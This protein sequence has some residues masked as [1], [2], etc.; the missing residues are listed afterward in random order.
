MLTRQLWKYSKQHLFSIFLGTVA[1][2]CLGIVTGLPSLFVK[3]LI[4]EVLVGKKTEHLPFFFFVFLGLFTAKA[5]FMYL[6]WMMHRVG[7]TI[8]CM[9]RKDFFDALID[10]SLEELTTFSDSS[11]K[12]YFMTDIPLM[13]NGIILFFRQGIKSVVETIFLLGIAWYRNPLLAALACTTLPLLFFFFK[14][15]S[16]YLRAYSHKTQ[17]ALEALNHHFQEI[18][19]GLLE[20]KMYQ[21]DEQEKNKYTA[22]NNAYTTAAIKS[23]HCEAAI[24]AL[25][26][27]FIFGALC[28]VLSIGLYQVKQA[29]ITIGDLTSFFMALLLAYQP[30]RRSVAII[31]EIQN[32][33]AAAE[34]ILSIINELKKRAEPKS[35]TKTLTFNQSIVLQNVSYSYNN[36]APVLK[37]INL[38]IYPGDRIALIGPSG[39]GKSTLC[40]LLL[41]FL[42]PT[43]GTIL[44]DEKALSSENKNSW[45]TQSTYINQHPFIFNCSI[46]ENI[47]YGNID[48]CNDTAVLKTL[49]KSGLLEI[50]KNEKID[51]NQNGKQLSGGEKQRLLLARALYAH[52]PLLILDE[53]TSAL[54]A[55][56]E[57]LI[58]ATIQA[59]PPTTTIILIAHKPLLIE[60]MTRIISIDKEGIL[61]LDQKKNS[62]DFYA[63][64]SI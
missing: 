64:K 38:M 56:K 27:F 53:A 12:T 24:P 39:S 63:N 31:A 62:S 21:T 2:G 25:V 8:S 9:I 42:T 61:E 34:R 13:Q 55:E 44:I 26:E 35:S 58:A 4:D 30:L 47:C 60:K 5:F 46:K 14:K 29:T 54:D 20:V 49:E 7:I 19:S 57:G 45:R 36:N 17:E 22:Y 11:I 52:R 48:H 6:S 41:G 1:A 33:S 15:K 51:I 23:A 28:L 3:S 40:N 59:L 16:T 37:N 18:F 43:H 32:S 50:N 10:T